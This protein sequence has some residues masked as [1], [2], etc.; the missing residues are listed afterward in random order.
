[1]KIF[2]RRTTRRL[3]F[4]AAAFAIGAPTLW[5]QE[6]VLVSCGEQKSCTYERVYATTLQG[7]NSVKVVAAPAMGAEQL[8]K[9]RSVRLS[10][11]PG[12]YRDPGSGALRVLGPGGQLGDVVLPAKIP[13]ALRRRPSPWRGRCSR[14]RSS[15]TRRC[16]ACCPST[17][18]SRC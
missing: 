2:S 18:S 8:R 13:M 11:L 7:R 15:R 12:L 14:T 6:S 4:S 16:G 17:G 3:C 10:S 5:A 9:A 1:M